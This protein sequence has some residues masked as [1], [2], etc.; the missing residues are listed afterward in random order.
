MPPR[1]HRANATPVVAT[2]IKA[3]PVTDD[4]HSVPQSQQSRFVLDLSKKWVAHVNVSKLGANP[5]LDTTIFQSAPIFWIEWVGPP[6]SGCNIGL[7][8]I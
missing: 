4:T 7:M 2:G 8:E 6:D 1:H 3:T 5:W